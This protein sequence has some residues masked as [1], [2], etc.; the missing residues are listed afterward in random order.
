MSSDRTVRIGCSLFLLLSLSS[1]AFARSHEGRITF[2]RGAATIEHEQKV[3]PATLGMTVAGSTRLTT[4]DD[5]LAEIKF[6]DGSLIRLTG[7]T[8][9]DLGKLWYTKA[10]FGPTHYSDFSISEGTAYLSLPVLKHRTLNISAKHLSWS[11]G[12][13][14]LDCRIMVSGDQALISVF[15][16]KI[17]VHLP[18][19]QPQSSK[20]AGQAEN[21]NGL[22]AVGPDESLRGNANTGL[23]TLIAHGVD[24]MA[25]DG[26]IPEV[27]GNGNTHLAFRNLQ[28][29]NVTLPPVSLADLSAE[30]AEISET[31]IWYPICDA[32]E[33]KTLEYT[34]SDRA[35]L[36][37]L[38]KSFM[39]RCYPWGPAGSMDTAGN[40]CC[41][42]I[43]G[44]WLWTP[45][46][47]PDF[48]DHGI[49]V[50]PKDVNK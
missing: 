8:T 30:F 46:Q 44:H 47:G 2:V 42:N 24:R 14:A 32:R 33:G 21:W 37:S 38:P 7:N 49:D 23:V 17:F 48:Q 35:P 40:S 50:P 13:Q 31:P 36:A 25:A 20:Y 41:F 28:R 19:Y 34:Y 39:V 16:G 26:W 9:V 4:G 18:I 6:E 45:P 3:E 43:P 22:L 1:F 27:D 10:W 15:S 5:G 11:T 12:D 29:T